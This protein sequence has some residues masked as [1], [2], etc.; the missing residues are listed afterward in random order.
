MP[1]DDRNYTPE[2]RYGRYVEEPYTVEEKSKLPKILLFIL[3]LVALIF[4]LGT[5]IAFA[6]KKGKLGHEY[7]QAD[8]SPEKVINRSG[9]SSSRV[10]T[11]SLGQLRIKTKSEKEDGSSSILVISPWFSYPENDV[12]LFEE[13]SKKDRQI[14]SIV[15]S[16][17][18]AHTKQELLAEGEKKI[19]EDLKTLINEQLVLGDLTAIYFDEYIF[20]DEKI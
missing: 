1:Y 16:Y 17:F 5:I 9:R 10:T 11:S 15:N 14:K 20:F 4:I 13:I 3:I 12:Q 2:P 8:P 7:R 6:T 19:K 18:S